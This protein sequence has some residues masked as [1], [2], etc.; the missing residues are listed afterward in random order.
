MFART[1]R[2]VIGSAYSLSGI[3][4][5]F[6]KGSALYTHS[7]YSIYL[8]LLGINYFMGTNIGRKCKQAYYCPAVIDGNSNFS[9]VSHPPELKNSNFA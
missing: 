4:M 8:L 6:V 2:V 1:E 7:N 9:S 3:H 5:V